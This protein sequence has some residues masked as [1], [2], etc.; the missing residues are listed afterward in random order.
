[1]FRSSAGNNCVI[2]GN[3]TMSLTLPEHKQWLFERTA[4]EAKGFGMEVLFELSNTSKPW[5]AYLR[6]A[7]SS[8]PAFYQAYWRNVEV[9]DFSAG[10]RLDPKILI[11][12][13]GA[14][15]SLQYHHRRAEHWRVVEG[16]VKIFTGMDADSVQERI[17][18]PGEV[19]RLSC[20]EWHRLVG[21][22]VWGRVAEIW[23]HTDPNNPSDESDIVRVEDDYGR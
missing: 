1:M 14:R 22:D 23:E 17:H 6:L 11:V 18:Y 12:A 21:L 3:P 2:S 5:G 19:I 15:L 9:P 20:G 4:A 7:E 16:P 8:I 13:P 10:L